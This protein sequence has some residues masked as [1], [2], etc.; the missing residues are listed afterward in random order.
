MNRF[1]VGLSDFAEAT[2]QDE[3]LGKVLVR[4]SK[5]QRRALK[6]L[7]LDMDTPMETLMHQAL[8]LLLR[9]H[10]REVPPSSRINIDTPT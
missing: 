2:P 1:E 6:Q 10:G 9:H 5:S 3:P 7:A 4:F 8:V